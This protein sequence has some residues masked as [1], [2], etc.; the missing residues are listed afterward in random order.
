LANGADPPLAEEL[1]QEVLWAVI[2][3]LREGRVQQPAHLAAFVWGTARNLLNDRIRMRSR[4]KTT[5][6]TDG[7]DFPSPTHQH[8]EFE[9][10]H[11]AHQAIA[12][13]EPHERA[14]LLLSLVDGLG[15]DEIAHRLGILPEAVRQRKSRALKKLGEI[16]RSPVTS[17]TQRTTL[18]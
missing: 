14:V 3:A 5:S 7:V 18:G 17:R 6:I 1:V 4:N 13:L 15:P 10:N 11:T 9:R 16:F 8:E 12:L 2:S